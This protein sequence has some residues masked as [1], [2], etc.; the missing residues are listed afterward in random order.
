M[1]IYAYQCTAC[2]FAQDEMQ[3]VSDAVAHRLKRR[4]Q[5]AG[6]NEARAPFPR[7]RHGCVSGV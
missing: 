5:K 7:L 2:G 6:G 4:Q 3:K 1:P